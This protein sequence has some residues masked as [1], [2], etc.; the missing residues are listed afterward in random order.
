MEE[1]L[2]DVLAS[3]AR[4]ELRVRQTMRVCE[5]S[6]LLQGHYLLRLL[7]KPSAHL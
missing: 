7:I 4:D 3:C 1:S 5:F 2:Q 6:D